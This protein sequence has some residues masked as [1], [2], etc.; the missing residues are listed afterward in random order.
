MNKYFEWYERLKIVSN[1]LTKCQNRLKLSNNKR[2]HAAAACHIIRITLKNIFVPTSNHISNT[3]RGMS[4]HQNY[5][6]KHL[7]TKFQLHVKHS[8]LLSH[9][10]KYLNK[11]LYAKFQLHVKDSTMHCCHIRMNLHQPLLVL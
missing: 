9:H 3:L 10:N 1:I 7:Y 5:V 2:P 8:A 11:H 4:H 6:N